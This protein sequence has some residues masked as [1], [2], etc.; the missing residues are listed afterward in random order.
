MEDRRMQKRRRLDCPEIIEHTLN[1]L[2]SAEGDTIRDYEGSSVQL[3]NVDSSSSATALIETGDAAGTS[4]VCYGM[5]EKLPIFSIAMAVIISSPTPVSAYLNE[6]GI[7]Q[8]SS[9]GACV[10][11]LDDR[12]LRCLFKLRDEDHI[13]I[14]FML[15]TATG[16]R[17]LGRKT[18]PVALASAIIYG[19]EYLSNEVGDFLDRCGYVFQDPFG[20]D[21]NVPYIN[22]HCLSTLFEAPRMTLELQSPYSGHNEFTLSNSLQALETTEDLPECQQ[23]AALKTELHRHQKQ[24]L[25]FFI[26]RESQDSIRHVWHEK[27]LPDGRVIYMNK[28][29]GSYEATPPPV[30]N[31]GILADGM[32]LGKTLQMISLIALDRESRQPVQEAHHGPTGNLRMAT[33]VV[34][35]L[36]LINV[37]EYQLAY[38]LR[39]S[40]LTWRRYHGKG[41]LNSDR[42][43]VCPDIVLT[44]Y[45]T[46][47]AEHKPN[48]R[49]RSIL[50][51]NHWRRIILDEAHIIRNRTSTSSAISELAA[52]SRWAV[53][54]TPIQNSFRDI[55][56]ILRVLR[57]SPYDTTKSFDE[58][59]IEPFRNGDVREGSRRLKALCQPIMIRRPMSVIV[60]PDRVDH[61]RTIQFSPEEWREY[62]KIENSFRELPNAVTSSSS[63]AHFSMS[64]IQLINKLRLFCNLGLLT[65]TVSLGSEQTVRSVSEKEESP[66]T[67]VTSEVM[68]GGASCKQCYQ[69]IN[70]PDA[71]PVTG[72]ISP[73]AYYSE[74]CKLY[75]SSCADMGNFQRAM[76]I[77][78]CKEARCVLR[79]LSIRI[80]QA[81]QNEQLLTNVYPGET[82]KIQALVQ[83][84]RNCLPEKSVVFSFW[85]S[86]LTLAQKALTAT[87]IRCKRIDGSISLSE[88]ERVVR[89]FREDQDAKVIL[90]TI[91]CG[92]VGLDL[93][94]ASRAHL[95]EPQWNPAIEEQALSRV[96]R[97]GQRRP[98]ETFRYLMRNSIE[99]SVALVKGKKQLLIEI[100][101]QTVQSQDQD[102]E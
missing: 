63:E 3:N 56:G 54:G 13:E 49:E 75:C 15:E 44:T 38:H 6:S 83:E 80:A 4:L 45:Q 28:M 71:T 19:P 16:A 1:G 95:L 30:W 22:P 17:S 14:Q 10:G 27:A 68:L 51:G 59:I 93:T 101:Q 94:T 5:L 33:L 61:V 34:V 97:M 20:C 102:R 65:T 37:W 77:S 62:E 99:E 79:P 66:E 90:V 89:E 70:V 41:R 43:L 64:M 32:G 87:G 35:P 69:V 53:T 58:D 84:V 55:G 31:G 2:H 23:P 50:F 74:C 9:D 98:V 8:R 88:R 21:H 73:Y 57:F 100:L 24:A 67:V 81:V 48:Y 36:S 78:C 60:L 42:G 92:G 47:Q 39:P 12:P 40:T 11:K 46:V 91:S 18:R 76:E 26:M 85:T 29:T 52:I 7:V 82:S 86:S 96:H 72:R 25:W